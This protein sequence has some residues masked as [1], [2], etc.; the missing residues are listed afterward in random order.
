VNPITVTRSTE[1]NFR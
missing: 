1:I